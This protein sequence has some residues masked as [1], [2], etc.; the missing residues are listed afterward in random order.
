M[1]HLKKNEG[2]TMI[3]LIISASVIV[4]IFSFILANFK[5]SQTKAGLDFSLKQIINGIETARGFTLGGKIL[6]LGFFPAGGY[7]IEFRANPSS[8][9]IFAIPSLGG[10]N[11]P[12]SNEHKEFSQIDFISPIPSTPQFGFIAT[13]DIDQNP[14]YIGNYFRIVFQS[15]QLIYAEWDKE[16][17]PC[18]EIPEIKYVAGMLKDKT[19]GRQSYFFVSL[20]SGSVFGSLN[21]D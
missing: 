14:C 11:Y 15:P 18:N 10:E 7:G 6:A 4:I 20:V 5:I 21:Y 9:Q 3:E 13:A 19:N 16:N 2:F 12:L 1:N 8:Y 17:Y